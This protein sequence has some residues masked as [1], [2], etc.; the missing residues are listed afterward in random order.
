MIKHRQDTPQRKYFKS[1]LEAILAAYN[2]GEAVAYIAAK[3][4]NEEN[5]LLQ[6]CEQRGYHSKPSHQIDGIEYW[7]VYGWREIYDA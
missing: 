2:K 3:N 7:K 5:W 1:I 6:F 4:V